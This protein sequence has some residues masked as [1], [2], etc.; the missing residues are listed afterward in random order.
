MLVYMVE[1]V[2]RDARRPPS[3]LSVWSSLDRA[4][5]WAERNSIDDDE[6]HVAIRVQQVD[7]TAAAS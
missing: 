4:Q 5:A 3:V 2:Y 1:R 7:V 6:S